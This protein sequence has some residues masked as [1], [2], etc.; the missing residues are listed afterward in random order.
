MKAIHEN[1]RRSMTR[2]VIWRAWGILFLAFVTYLITGNWIQTTIITIAHHGTF[3]IVYY[4][5]ERFWLWLKWLRESKWK[6]F[7]RVF[8]Y[9]I[10]LGNIILGLISYLVT[11]EVK[12][13]TLITGIY[14]GNK[15][16]MYVVYDKIWERVKWGSAE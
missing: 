3:V 9:E 12:A 15:L 7:A 1:H 6:Y 8:T 13:M 5:H 14:I 16:W 2:S 11:G 10:I 4:L